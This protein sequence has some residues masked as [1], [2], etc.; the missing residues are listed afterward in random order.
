M[1]AH[2]E[3]DAPR[4]VRPRPAAHHACRL[5]LIA[6]LGLAPVASAHAASITTRSVDSA[7]TGW[8]Q[9][10]T[11]LTP[12]GV[13]PS[14]FHK[15]GELR[16]D[17][18]IEASPLYVEA[19]ATPS[20]TRDLLIVATTANTIYAFDAATDAVVW[21]TSLGPAVEHLKDALYD[22]W[23]ITATPVVDPAS[24]TLYVV[25]LAW[26]NGHKVYRLFGLRLSDGSEE[27]QSQP[28]D[29]FSVQSHGKFFRNGEQIVRTGLALWRNPAGQKAI[30]FGAS[31]GED[32]NGANG[33]VIAFNIQRL[34]QGG[35]VAPA[36][37]CSTPNGGGGGIWMAGQA[38]AIDEDDPHRDIYFAT[39]NGP[40]NQQFGADDLGESVVRLRFDPAANTL[41]V[42]DWFTPF[43]DADRDFDHRDQDLSAAGVMLIPG[44]QSVL[45]GGKEGIFYNVDRTAMGKLS[46]AS[47]VQPGFVGSFT[48]AA[49]FNYLANPNQAT[50]TDG[51]SGGFGGARTFIPHP[52]DGGRTRHIHGGPAFYANGSQRFV[53]VMGENSTL[54][55]F[56]LTGST[57]SATPVGE[58]SPLTITS[59]NTP[60]PGGMPGG[61]LTVTSSDASGSDGIVWS[62]SPRRSMW[63]DPAAN[64]VPVPSILR[65]FDPI[66]AGGQLA[67]LWNSEIDVH[68]AVGSASKWQPPLV[69]DGRVYI[70]TYNDR[71]VIYGLTAPDLQARDVRRT[72]IL[73][74]GTTRPGQDL[75]IRGGIDHAFG[76]SQGRNCPTTAPPAADDPTYF[77]CAIRIEHRNTINYGA[78]HEPYAITNRWQLNDTHL[79]WYGAEEFQTFERRGPNGQGLGPAQGTPL[80]W[81][82]DSLA[83]GRTVLR[84]GFGF[85][86]ENL[87][88]G[89]GDHYWMLD[90]D[91]DCGTAV[92]IGGVHWFELKSFITGVA[93]G[94]EPD[95]LQADR[96]WP[97]GNHFAQC[98][99]INIFER[100][101]SAVT[102]RDFD[103]LNQCSFPNQERRC[104][105][106]TAQRC[107]TVAGANV[108][109]DA[110]NCVAARQLCQVTTGTCC[111][112][113]N[114]DFDGSNRN[115]L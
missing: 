2:H 72:M 8:N 18:K 60:P 26:E 49:G 23:G 69:A 68:D 58:S 10:E 53:Y 97:S 12:A 112:P 38:V 65:A 48:P 15:V 103:P 25:R 95:I 109:Q 45:A 33:W 3:I 81:T 91:M 96:P 110:Q 87:D 114:G 67:E 7:R 56:R 99:R 37:W 79:D 29:G 20:G 50:T 51:V 74:K 108:W 57:L 78:N 17:D 11:V 93:N 44:T 4:P 71:V 111:T 24:A 40:Y 107:A 5:I 89:L 46:H 98:G 27:I 73:I 30:V 63:R 113:S 6:A 84:H 92:A 41:N 32:V 43:R 100:G 102:Y 16:V 104:N 88:A 83:G 115:C 61:F 42:V 52:A 90:V 70:V 36:V 34:R 19:V 13:T 39:G 54:R 28:V 76:N 59:G 80:D 22:K 106:G 9:A 14:T 86:K 94:W 47:L 82:S 75:F 1:P 35:N 66:P 55:A 105:G 101:S 62:I 21:T 31:G 64:A 77:N 85:L